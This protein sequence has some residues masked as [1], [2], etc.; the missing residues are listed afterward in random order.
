MVVSLPGFEL[1]FL[2]RWAS[3]RL[4]LCWYPHFDFK[5]NHD[6]HDYLT[7]RSGRRSLSAAID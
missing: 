6:D 1:A 7:L 5:E 4:A 2:S 3:E